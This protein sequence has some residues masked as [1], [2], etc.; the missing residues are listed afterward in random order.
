MSY[1]HMLPRCLEFYFYLLQGTVIFLFQQK[2][3]RFFVLRVMLSA[4][5]SL[6]VMNHLY[7]VAIMRFHGVD[8]LWNTIIYVSALFFLWPMVKFCFEVSWSE[9]CFCAV[10]GYGAQFVQS[11]TSEMIYRYFALDYVSKNWMMVG[12]G[13]VIFGLLYFLFGRKLKKGQN[14]NVDKW[15]LMLLLI[16]VIVVEIVL[17]YNLRQQ[18]I[19]ALDR[20][21]MV[22]DCILLTICSAAVLSMQ[23]S[24]LMQQD[25][26]EELKIIKQMW[27]KDREQYRISSETIDLINRKCH[28]MRFQIRSIGKN[29]NVTPAALKDM[30]KTISIYEAMYQTGCRALDIILTEKSLFCQANGITIS[31]IADA[32]ELRYLT[33][34]DIYSLFGNLL[35]NAIH[36]VSALGA[37]ERLIG[38]TIRKCGEMLSINSHN[39][40]AGEVIL[41]DGLPLT[42]SGS[43]DYHGFGVKSIAAIVR[44]YGGVV[45]FQTKD[46]VFNLNILFPLDALQD[47]QKRHQKRR[48]AALEAAAN[49][50]QSV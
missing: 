10:A 47:A 9:A 33:E 3:R 20:E 49:K 36:A 18:W 11:I 5:V 38:L 34:P 40:F 17:C 41:R 7:Y 28:D 42:S 39:L 48:E 29:A 25:L 24:L 30:E 6:A 14:F 26:T 21:H 19:Y 35:D 13:L 32:E 44:K 31:C 46:N 8:Y 45:S 12:V 23:F 22:C 1:F 50:E 2:A 37:D 15:Y 43:P 4:S 27:R 16:C